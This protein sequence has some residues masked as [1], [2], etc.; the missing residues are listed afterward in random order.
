MSWL[1]FLSAL[2]SGGALAGDVPAAPSRSE[3]IARR[4]QLARH[5]RFPH[6]FHRCPAPRHVLRSPSADPGKKDALY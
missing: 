5:E 3:P 2:T 1:Y 6:R 4:T